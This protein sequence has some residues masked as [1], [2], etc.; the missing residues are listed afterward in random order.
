VKGVR[1][2]ARIKE[3]VTELKLSVRNQRVVINLVN[4]ELDHMV[5]TE[6]EKTDIVPAVLVPEDEEIVRY[7][8]DLRPLT[9]MPDSSKAV[10]A[11][12]GL[13]AAIIH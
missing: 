1:T 10:K 6:L 11:I 8:L 9:D 2:I 7:D 13:M 12:D 5:E 4:G 3:L